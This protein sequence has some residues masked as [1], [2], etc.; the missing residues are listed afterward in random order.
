MVNALDEVGRVSDA[1]LVGR[2]ERLHKADRALSAKLLVHLGEMEARGLFRARAFS[3]M[4][5]YCRSGLGMSEGEASLRILAARVGR[6]FPL[7]VQRL[8]AGAVHLSAIRLLA[9]HFTKENHVE[10]AQVA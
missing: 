3:S 8:G 1:E 10:H 2:L 5:E 6:R 4:F 9:P 7:V